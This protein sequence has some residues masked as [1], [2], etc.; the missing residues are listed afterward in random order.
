[1]GVK[2]FKGFDKNLQC[3]GFQYETGKEYEHEDE[4]K[5]CGSGFHSCEYPLDVLRHYPS[6]DANR[7]C[8]A[9]ADGQMKSGGDKTVSSKIK[10][11]LEIGL[12]GLI[13]AAVKFIFEKVDWKNAQES[14]TG[15]R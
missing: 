6:T 1:M 12:N 5:L 4:I 3:R 7:F 15:N 9:E 10:I 14:N 2:T 13:D 8:E 11:G